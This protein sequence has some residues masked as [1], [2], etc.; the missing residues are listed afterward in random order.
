[1]NGDMTS[2][3]LVET[4]DLFAVWKYVMIDRQTQI[5]GLT[6]PAQEIL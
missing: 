2:K 6:P 3:C 4:I 1:M 5:V